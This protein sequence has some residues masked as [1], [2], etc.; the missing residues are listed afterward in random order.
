[1][2]VAFGIIISVNMVFAYFA[3]S[4]FPGLDGPKSYRA[5]LNFNETIE[6]GRQQQIDGLSV[7]E[8]LEG[9]QLTLSFLVRGQKASRVEV[10]SFAMRH[11]T[12]AG[13][14]KDMTREVN[15]REHQL[16][17]MLPTEMLG[18]W[19][20]DLDAMVNDKPMKIRRKLFIPAP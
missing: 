3:F 5:G 19:S 7:E 20:M 8:Q 1:M 9:R 17:T 2:V 16:M 15:V 13:R 4:E 18:N 6:Q 14:D 11:P 12:R 10:I